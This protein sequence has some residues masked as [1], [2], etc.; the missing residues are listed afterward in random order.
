MEVIFS[1]RK[2]I[3]TSLLIYGLGLEGYLGIQSDRHNRSKRKLAHLPRI[4]TTQHNETEPCMELERGEFSVAW[5]ID[6]AHY[7][8]RSISDV[9]SVADQEL[10]A[11]HVCVGGASAHA[12]LSATVQARGATFRLPRNQ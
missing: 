12:L 3:Y 5:P 2:A 4:H 8:H 11:V 6:E 7:C 9:Q 10:L 1:V